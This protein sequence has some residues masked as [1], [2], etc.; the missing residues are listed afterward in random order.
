[1]RLNGT[2]AVA[3]LGKRSDADL[4]WETELLRYLDREGMAVPVPIATA[5][6]RDFADGL[7]VMTYVE[8]SPPETE[9]DWRRVAN[10]LREL[11]LLTPTPATSAS[12]RTASR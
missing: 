2:L 6:G 4:S 9:L 11:H 12:L 5:D 1:V 8:G 3:R 7:V 10:T